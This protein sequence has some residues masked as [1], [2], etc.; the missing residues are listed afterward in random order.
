MVK[1]S[2]V[3]KEKSIRQGR[4]AAGGFTLV[5]LMVVLAIIAA[6]AAFSTPVLRT[7]I[8]QQEFSGAVRDTLSAL[9]Q[10]R[11]VAV[12]ENEAVVFTVDTA[13]GTYQAFVDD[14]GGDLTDA[15]LDGVPDADADFNGI[16]DNAQ[17]WTLDANE[18]LIAN[19]TVP[20]SVT[21]T[22]ADFSGN[23]D[24]RFDNRGFPISSGAVNVLTNGTLSLSNTLGRA[25]QITLF[26]SGHTRVQ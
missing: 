23:P 11:L 20:D 13:N 16:L 21:I 9:R 25:Q 19:G 2:D 5:E 15:D 26:R 18:R 3:R 6:L 14:G 1:V 7:M 24:F 22:A 10:A 4:Q 17:N 8:L 12:E